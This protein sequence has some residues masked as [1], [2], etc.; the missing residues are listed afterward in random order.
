[1][2]MYFLRW[3]KGR[4]FFLTMQIKKYVVQQNNRLLCCT[5]YK[6]HEISAKKWKK[7]SETTTFS[8]FQWDIQQGF[9]TF[10]RQCDLLQ[11][12]MTTSKLES[13]HRKKWKGTPESFVI[14]YNR[15]HQQN[16][17]KVDIDNRRCVLQNSKG[18]I[19]GRRLVLQ[20]SKVLADERR[21]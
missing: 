9:T 3:C 6:F 12:L 21:I 4:A 16:D 11:Q 7:Y 14:I 10:G 17:F 15:R 19:Y 5:T 2:V 8:S 1:M 20:D 13:T 18:L